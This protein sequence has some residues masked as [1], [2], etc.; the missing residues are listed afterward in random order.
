[1]TFRKK[2]TIRPAKQGGQFVDGVWQDGVAE[3]PFEI[4]ASVQP[5]SSGDYDRM[6]QRADGARIERMVRIYTDADLKQ[7]GN[8]EAA[9]SDGDVLLF[10]GCEF[11][12]RDKSEW[13]SGIISHYR[14]LAVKI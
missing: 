6:M 4:L 3:Q 10:D 8:D 14:Y 5:A 11:L 1:M 7:S 9:S 12:I 2:V 13:Q